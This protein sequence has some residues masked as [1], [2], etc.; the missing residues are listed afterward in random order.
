M[1]VRD[2]IRSVQRGLGSSRQSSPVDV[3]NISTLDLPATPLS[4]GGPI[5][6]IAVAVLG[7]FFDTGDRNYLRRVL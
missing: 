5:S 6:P 2:A 3:Q 1:A 4:P 7:V